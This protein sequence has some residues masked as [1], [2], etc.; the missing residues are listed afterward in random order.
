MIDHDQSSDNKRKPLLSVPS[1]ELSASLPPYTDYPRYTDDPELGGPLWVNT[2]IS[3]RPVKAEKKRNCARRCHRVCLAFCTTLLLLICLPVFLRHFA[4]F[5]RIFE[6]EL[7]P[8]VLRDCID[9]ADWQK[10]R[11]EL[12]DLYNPNRDLKHIAATTF[13]LPVDSDLLYLVARGALSHGKVTISSSGEEGS[14]KMVVHVRMQYAHEDALNRTKVC[15]LSPPEGGIGVG[16]FS[17]PTMI[18]S[19]WHTN[20]EIDVKLPPGSAGVPT[21][22]KEFTTDMPLFMH[23]VHDMQTVLFESV[24]LS[25]SLLPIVANSL[26]A[27]EGVVSTTNAMIEGTFNTSSRLALRTSNAPIKATVF[28]FNDNEGSPT[29]LLAYTSNSRIDTIIELNSTSA[30]GTDGTFTVDARTSNAPIDVSTRSAPVGHAL[31]LT[32]ETSNSPVTVALSPT[33]EGTFDVRTSSLFTSS[34]DVHTDIPDPAGQGRI[35]RAFVRGVT[36]GHVE[37][38]AEWEEGRRTVGRVN[39]GTSNS[40]LK[41]YV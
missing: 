16:I 26:N 38:F 40:P 3:V 34:V 36:R 1:E 18:G 19:K 9:L 6:T 17:P 23:R 41:L 29:E 32:A 39:I 7:D 35:R 28:M 15:L 27:I 31:A 22:I 12:D 8:E 14:D 21:I 11:M 2:Q 37:G 33:W 30:N 10:G 4:W 5:N 24:S 13:E 25:T 20:I